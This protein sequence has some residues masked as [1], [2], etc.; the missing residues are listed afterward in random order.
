MVPV[1]IEVQVHDSL[2]NLVPNY[3]GEVTVIASSANVAGAGLLTITGGK[4]TITVTSA[5]AESVS[6][7]M[8]DPNNTGFGRNFQTMKFTP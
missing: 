7:Q 1:T 8:Q 5:V 2:G 6:F 4:G 3:N